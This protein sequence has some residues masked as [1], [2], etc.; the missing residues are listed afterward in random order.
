MKARIQQKVLAEA[1]AWA[2]RQVPSRPVQPVHA[3]LRLHATEDGLTVS[4][5]DGDTSTHSLLAADVLTP[6]T[7]VVAARFLAAVAGQ[8]PAGDVDLAYDGDQLTV[9]AE[10]SQYQLATLPAH[11]YPVLPVMPTPAGIVAGDLLAQAVTEV[12]HLADGTVAALP[13]M[14]GIR[15]TADGDRL[16]L[17]ATDRYRVGYRTVPWQPTGTPFETAVLPAQAVVEI[18]KG[19][20]GDVQ[21]AL[22]GPDSMLAGISA[23][24][25]TTLMRCLDAAAFPKVDIVV[26]KTFA[27]DAEVE[28][29]EL[30]AAVRRV[31]VVAEDKTPLRLQFTAD[32]LTVAAAA[33]DMARGRTVIP[34]QMEGPEQF[35]ISFNPRYLTDGMQGL[36]GAIHVQL[37]SA[38]RP[39]M[40]VSDADETCRYLAVPLK[41]AWSAAPA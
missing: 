16:S 36:T 15:V 26:P 24:G 35:R 6:G 30:L 25:R 21:L 19:A 29:E 20:R 18:V 5:T 33:G 31:M 10:G 28:A 27:A 17:V 12:A 13:A 2:A 32:S 41:D 9:T 14:A 4:G 11:E 40:F 7:V 8:L 22:P 39:V 34:C 37:T 38:T 3:G 1:A 23:A